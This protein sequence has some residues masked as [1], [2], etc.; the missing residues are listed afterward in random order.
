MSIL[1]RLASLSSAVILLFS[2]SVIAKPI[3]ATDIFTSPKISNLSFSPNNNYIAAVT[4]ED[5]V[6]HLSLINI[7]T[8]GYTPILEFGKY[9]KFEGYTWLDNETIYLKAFS[10]NRHRQALLKINYQGESPKAEYES[11]RSKGYLVSALPAEPNKVLYAKNMFDDD[12]SNRLY[13][14][15]YQELKKGTFSKRNVFEKGIKNVVHFSYDEHL[16]EL[17]AV[18]LLE[19]EKA[20]SV[21]RK[22]KKHWKKLYQIDNHKDTFKPIGLLNETTLAVLTNQKSN[23]IGLY[24]FDIPSQTITSLIYQHSKY[25]LTNAI[26][27]K[28]NQVKFVT[29]IENGQQKSHYLNEEKVSFLSELEPTFTQKHIITVDANSDESVFI[30]FSYSSDDAGR[31]YIYESDQKKLSILDDFLPALAQYKMAKTEVFNLKTTDNQEI[32]AFLTRPS[33][34]GNNVLLVMPHGGPIGVREYDT[35]NREVQYFV[36]RGYSVL[37]VNF[38]G[39][40]G[41]GK[42]FL[43][44]GKAQ[45]GKAIEDDITLAVNHVKS[46]YD[47]KQMCTMGSSYGGYSAMMLTIHHPNEYQCA[48]GTFGIYDL[49]LLFNANNFKAQPEFQEVVSE[50]VGPYTPELKN[51]SP[52]YL[53]D[54]ISVPVLLIAGEEDSIAEVEHS[55]RLA[56]LLNSLN[57]PVETLYYKN[58]GHGHQSWRWDRHQA[59]YVVD[60]LERTLQLPIFIENQKKAHTIKLA[61][62]IAIIA[63]GFNFENNVEIDSNKAKSYYKSAAEFGHLRSQ[64]NYALKLLGD[65]KSANQQAIEWLKKASSQAYKNS[66]FKLGNLYREGKY[67]DKDDPKAFDFFVLADKQGHDARAQLEMAK[68]YCL[69][70]GIEHDYSKCTSLFNINAL[71][72]S[73]DKKL[74]DKHTLKSVKYKQQL[75]RELFFNYQLTTRQLETLHQV[76][77]EEKVSALPISV[78]DEEFGQIIRKNWSNKFYEISNPFKMSNDTTFSVKFETNWNEEQ[79]LKNSDVIVFTHW[80]YIDNSGELIQEDF[81]SLQGSIQRGWQ[82]GFRINQ[83]KIENGTL[84]VILKDIFNNIIYQK[85]IKIVKG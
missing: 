15:S 64:H 72:D 66:S 40:A 79:R 32:E 70:L 51:F 83:D 13:K 33:N 14:L 50:V 57:K 29:Y 69:G 46:K 68:A 34:E 16:K 74:K 41:F 17:Y 25:D 65:K 39:S 7:E 73:K 1:N 20:I 37:R 82:A 47:Y 71:K 80:K 35:F 3:P 2:F 36:S 75:L 55:E 84:S 30:L 42:D 62:D 18:K 78:N 31:F 76:F 26:I 19:D 21:Y 53:A 5:G 22:S 45:F 60:Y 77:A 4:R 56:Y 59:A 12:P 11:I 24:E 81:N 58:T 85:T 49:P 28:N 8:K 6:T 10:S 9:D 48:I 27:G 61:N 38:R 63:D 44:S 52:V 67:A 54:K 43:N 23:T